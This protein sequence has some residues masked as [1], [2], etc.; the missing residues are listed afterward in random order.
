MDLH[1]EDGTLARTIRTDR[2]TLRPIEA[3][4][5]PAIV[6]A[7]NDWDVTRWLTLVPYPYAQADA[8][9][10]IAQA[11]DGYWVIDAGQGAI[12]AIS[13]KPDMGYWLA[14]SEHGKGYMTEAASAVAAEHFRI[15]GSPLVSGHYPDN[16][17]SRAVLLKLGFADTHL[18][19]Q[20]QVSTDRDVPTQRMILTRETFHAR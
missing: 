7:L 5:A 16:A 3:A 4:D 6:A 19:T 1:A 2:L 9:W 12:G 10:W 20:R 14:R 8:E 15:S 17:A 11:G 13:I 18:E